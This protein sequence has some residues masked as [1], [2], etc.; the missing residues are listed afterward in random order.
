[1]SAVGQSMPMVR[2]SI[3]P[4]HFLAHVEHCC[5]CENCDLGVHITGMWL[6]PRHTYYCE[7]CDAPFHPDADMDARV[8][9]DYGEPPIAQPSLCGPCARGER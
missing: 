7:N 9:G 4:D 6:C 3:N 5:D 2:V 8:G 1:M